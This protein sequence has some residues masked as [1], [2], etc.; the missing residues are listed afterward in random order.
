MNDTKHPGDAEAA[1]AIAALSP[2]PIRP[3]D[4]VTVREPFTDA[5]LEGR[6]SET[7]RGIVIVETEHGLL[8]YRSD[9]VVQD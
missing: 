4:W 5:Y 7:G 6:V 9:E 8:E 1:A 2:R 3:G